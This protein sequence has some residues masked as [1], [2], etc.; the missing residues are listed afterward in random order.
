MEDDQKELAKIGAEAVMRPFGDLI[1]KLFGGPFEEIGGMWKDSLAARRRIRQLALF[2]K[3]Q[4]AI[5]EDGFEPQKIPDNIWVSALQAASLQDDE[6]IQQRWANL[7]TNAANPD[8]DGEVAPTFV[9]IL[10]ELTHREVKILD[11]MYEEVRPKKGQPDWLVAYN[12]KNS[13]SMLKKLF[14]QAGLLQVPQFASGASVAEGKIHRAAIDHDNELVTYSL[15]VL[16][17]TRV[18]SVK[19]IPR[20]VE[21][22]VA[23]DDSA[24][25]S[26]INETINIETV[27]VYEITSLGLAFIKAC[28]T[29]GDSSRTD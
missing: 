1:N 27:D 25:L 19:T 11:L 2:R 26:S 5:D 6:S 21:L 17:R 9:A 4:K 12:Q 7:L 28:R 29:P 13:F 14:A 3:V 16:V 23:G 24:I 8:Y 20:P 10:N 18:F 15:D 22:R